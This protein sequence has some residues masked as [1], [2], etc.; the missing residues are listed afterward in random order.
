M[1]I[2]ASPDGYQ[3][4]RILELSTAAN[5]NIETFVRTHSEEEMEYLKRK[6]VGLAIMGERELA[7]RLTE[8]V[9]RSF[10]V[11]LARAR[12]L[13]EEETPTELAEK[14]ERL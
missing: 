9:L 10:G 7:R 4:R 6:R 1:L 2:I 5:A 3:A 14:A 12:L 13:V 11:P 8:H